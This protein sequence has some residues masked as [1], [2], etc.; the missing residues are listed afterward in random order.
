MRIVLK[1]GEFRKYM[2]I[3]Y[4]M[5]KVR[6][7]KLTQAPLIASEGIPD[8]ILMRYLEFERTGETETCPVC[9]EK[10]PVYEVVEE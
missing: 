2:N 8:T 6:I 7:P 10:L 9:G 3:P 5:Y 4:G 1:M